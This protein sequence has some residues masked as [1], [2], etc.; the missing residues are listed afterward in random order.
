MR[1]A[2]F[3]LFALAASVSAA[4]VARDDATIEVEASLVV[5]VPTPEQALSCKCA[6]DKLNG[7]GVHIN[8]NAQWYQCAYPNGACMWAHVRLSSTVVGGRC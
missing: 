1:F 6:A 8:Q 2:V 3:S 7:S 4:V 5:T